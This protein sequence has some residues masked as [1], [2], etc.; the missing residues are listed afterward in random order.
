M[1]AELLLE[2][3]EEYAESDRFKNTQFRQPKQELDIYDLHT[4]IEKYLE[5]EE[6]TNGS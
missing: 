3:I 1:N 2:I 4:I 5:K 6:Q